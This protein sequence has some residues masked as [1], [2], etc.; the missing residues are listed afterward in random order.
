MMLCSRLEIAI[1][2]IVSPA[3]FLGTLY[4]QF[5]P[6]RLAVL[7]DV[8]YTLLHVF[9]PFTILIREHAIKVGT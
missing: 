8:C 7:I 3:T 5:I 1:W 4:V 2:E 9:F 6:S